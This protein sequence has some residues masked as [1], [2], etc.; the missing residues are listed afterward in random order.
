MMGR[1]LE[2]SARALVRELP[3]LAPVLVVI[4]LLLCLIVPVPTPLLDLSLS[5]RPLTICVL[6]LDPQ[7][8]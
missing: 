8:R 5:G 4:V 7:A 1:D 6:D 3:G 2:L